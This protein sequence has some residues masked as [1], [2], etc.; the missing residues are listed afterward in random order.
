MWEITVEDDTDCRQYLKLGLLNVNS[1]KVVDW[2]AT[3]MTWYSGHGCSFEEHYSRFGRFDIARNNAWHQIVTP[4]IT[5]SKMKE[6]ELR[7]PGV[8]ER[9]VIA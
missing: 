7:G 2:I 8:Y 6:R 3:D 1:N 9:Q 4:L 5:W